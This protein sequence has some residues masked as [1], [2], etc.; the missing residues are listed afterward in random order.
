MERKAVR[1]EMRLLVVED[2]K[3]LATS[4]R[5]GLLTAGFAVDAVSCLAE[6]TAACR[7]NSYDLVVL[8]LGL[9]DGDGSELLAQL[10]RRNGAVPVL[11]L[12]ARGGLFDRVTNLNAGADDYLSK[13]FAFPELIARIRAL[14]RRPKS[15]L[16]PVLAVGGVRY[17]PARGEVTCGTSPVSLTIKETAVLE[18]FLRHH[19]ELVTRTMLLDQCWDE[20][21]DGLSNLVDVHVSRVRRKLAQAGAS[22]VIRTVRGAGFI[23]E[24]DGPR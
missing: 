20:T 6:A 21:Y 11:I 15:A 9:P 10:R 2:D 19:G 22:C 13:P 4:L 23:L 18:Y 16:P 12:T 7:V 5:A 1:I 14:L 17:D 8:D 3:A 24:E